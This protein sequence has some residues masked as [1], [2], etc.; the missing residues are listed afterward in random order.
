MKHG[1]NQDE[2]SV[3][4]LSFHVWMTAC[5]LREPT[6]PSLPRMFLDFSTESLLLRELLGIG[7]TRMAR[8]DCLSLKNS[9]SHLLG[10]PSVPGQPEGV[11]FSIDSAIKLMY[12]GS[13]AAA[14]V[15]EAVGS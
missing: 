12:S 13:N 15:N 9:K 10:N 4:H 5:G 8:Q 2:A 6:P 11:Q 1:G 14:V 3:G 7:Q